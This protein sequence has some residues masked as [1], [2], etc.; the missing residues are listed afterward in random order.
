MIRKFLVGLLALS[1]FLSGCSVPENSAIDVVTT[2]SEV[3]TTS[4]VPEEAAELNFASYGDSDYLQYVEDQFFASAESE[5]SSDDY[6]IEDVTATYVSREYLDELAYNSQENIYFG[7]TLSEIEAQFQ[8][9]SY[10]FSLGNDSQTEVRAKENY[11]DSFDRITQNVAIGVGIIL[12]SVSISL[13]AAPAGA[14]TVATVFAVSAKSGTVGAITSAAAGALVSGAVTAVETGD[15][16]AAL[17]NAAIAGSEGLKWGAL[18]GVVGGG[19]NKALPLR[20]GSNSKVPSPVDSEQYALWKYGG[21]AQKSYVN[22]K[23]VPYGVAGSAR[24]DLVV[25]K[26]NRKVAVEVKN[27]ALENNFPSSLRTLRSQ[28]NFRQTHLP[29]GWSQRVM[30]DLRGR[31]YSRK[32]V[33]EHV[34]ILKKEFPEVSFDVIRG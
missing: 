31:G 33:N 9:T 7:Y 11:D 17:K 15:L 22:G 2:T 19:I 4:E 21:T 27:Y 24:P 5:F 20:G 34:K 23:E 16:K 30:L 1:V 28:I 8:D 6:A 14:T 12:I 26:G 32:F 18:T 3:S 13:L 25:T 29:V 10:V